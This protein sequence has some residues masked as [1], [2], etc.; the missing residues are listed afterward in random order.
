[1]LFCCCVCSS[2]FLFCLL[3][4]NKSEVQLACGNHPSCVE[5]KKP[6]VEVVIAVSYQQYWQKSYYLSATDA[7]LEQLPVNSTEH[8]W[9]A[10][11][12]YRLADRWRLTLD[13]SPV[14]VQQESV[15]V[16]MLGLS[17]RFWQQA[18]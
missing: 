1:V 18:E 17:Y 8:G 15:K 12:S 10:G 4:V 3:V 7:Q 6:A 14:D 16:W 2:A 9:I 5:K 11:V 13:Y